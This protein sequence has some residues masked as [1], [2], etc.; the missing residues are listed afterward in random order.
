MPR[1]ISPRRTTSLSTSTARSGA[2]SSA[3]TSF[4]RSLCKPRGD[5][6]HGPLEQ[7]RRALD[8][9]VVAVLERLVDRLRGVPHPR[10]DL[11]GAV[12]KL[13]LQIEVAVAIGPKLLLRDDKNLIDGLLMAQLIH[14]PARHSVSFSAEFHQNPKR[15]RG[16]SEPPL[17]HRVL[18]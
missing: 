2:K 18:I 17:A 4:G 14:E 12:G 7:L 16:N 3:L 10:A 13:H 1:R 15:E 11:A 5:Q 9:D 6:L 8:A